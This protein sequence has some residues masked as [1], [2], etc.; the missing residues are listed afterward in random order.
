MDL[1][2]DEHAPRDE[3]AVAPPDD[4]HYATL[5][6][7]PARRHALRVFEAVRRAITDIPGNCSDRGVAHLKLTW[8]QTEL[9]Q[10]ADGRARHPLAQ[11]LLPLLGDEP[12]LLEIA[13]RLLDATIRGLNQPALADH[14][15]L[16]AWLEQQQG[17]VFDYYIAERAT[18]GASE[19]R[20]LVDIAAL[21]EL[22]YALRGLRQHRR[23]TPLLLPRD[24]LRAA[25]LGDDAVRGALD[26]RPL[27]AMLAPWAAWLRAQL[28]AHCA[29][30]PRT[31]RRRQRLLLTLAACAGEA[32]ALTEADGCRV[33]EQRVDLLPPRKL[34]LAWRIA[35]WG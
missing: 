9:A 10:L 18:L 29:A 1:N 4:F 19:L 15:A 5:Y 14:A 6:L 7:P 32:L 16:I 11:A 13:N 22:A 26:S 12:R 17:G 3:R 25:G 34:W 23:A 27:V 35:H 21:L 20:R 33:L 8:W 24:A 31:L 30:L 28:L 2:A